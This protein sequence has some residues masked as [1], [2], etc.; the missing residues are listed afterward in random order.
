MEPEKRGRKAAASWLWTAMPPFT[1]GLGTAPAMIWAAAYRRSVAQAVAAAVYTALFVAC[2]AAPE[3]RLAGF[4]TAFLA[5]NWL[6]GTVHA[7]AMRRWTF[8]LER[9]EE[10]VPSVPPVP[11]APSL[12]DR[13]RA[14]LNATEEEKQARDVARGIAADDP[15]RAHQLRI[16]RVDLPDRAFPDGGLVDVNNVPPAAL[17]TAT[18]LPF[19]VAEQIATVGKGAGGFGS[20]EEL[21]A[22]TQLPPQTFDH[23]ADRLYFPPR[24]PS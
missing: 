2:V 18:G 17:V 21:C 14:V 11:A 16:G 7:L 9:A 6:L 4:V 1:L 19:T 23:L 10:P 8:G 22:L 3:T 5:V 24:L 15:A 20:P 13:Q 12:L